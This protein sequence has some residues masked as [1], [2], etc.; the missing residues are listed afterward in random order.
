MSAHFSARTLRH[1]IAIGAVVFSACSSPKSDAA[2]KPSAETSTASAAAPVDAVNWT[3]VDSAAGRA[4]VA[5]PG[6]VHRFNFPRGDLKVMAAGVPIKPALALGSWVAMKA[7]AGGVMAMGDLVLTEDEV[8]PVIAALQSAGIDQTAIHHHLLHE[9]PRI[10]YVHV[11]A[12]GDAVKVANGVR[13]ALALTKTPAAAPSAPAPVA[14]SN[15]GIDTGAVAKALGYHG[16]INGGV[17]QVSVAR[18]ESIHE[19]TFEIPPSMGISTAINFQP[20]GNGKAAITGDFVMLG[21]EVNEVIRALRDGGIE[22]TALH[23]HMLS[24]EPRLY[25]MHFW[26]NDDATKLATTLASALGHTNSKKAG[27]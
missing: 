16:R 13:A 15:F 10:V 18:A 8:S 3:A 20:T 6:D 9:S 22:V 1:G 24:E 12:H 4:S 26:A 14:E 27:P 25:F 21:T 2:S 5:Q 7:V 19:G 17:Y 11:H 23:S